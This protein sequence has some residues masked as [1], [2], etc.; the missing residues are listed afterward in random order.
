MYHNLH[1]SNFLDI[2]G[3]FDIDWLDSLGN[4]VLDMVQKYAG[5][6]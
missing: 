2:F 5:M 6:E 1:N 4:Y 3:L